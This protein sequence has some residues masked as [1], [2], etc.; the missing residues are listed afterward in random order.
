MTDVVK[1][2]ISMLEAVLAEGHEDPKVL[3]KDIETILAKLRRINEIT[4]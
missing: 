4:D 3:S 2:T 1:S